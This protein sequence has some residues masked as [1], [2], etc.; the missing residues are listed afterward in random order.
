MDGSKIIEVKCPSSKPLNFANSKRRQA[1]QVVIEY[2][3]L[4][5]VMAGIGAFLVRSF[6]SR[7]I[8]EPGLLVA[9][10]NQILQF[11]AQ[12]NPED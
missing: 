7:D 6:A 10:W 4:I 2:V 12:D 11:V 3:L 5:V 8:D 1:G 9:K